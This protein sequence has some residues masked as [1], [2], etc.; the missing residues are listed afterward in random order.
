MFM[1]VMYLLCESIRYSDEL[2]KSSTAKIHSL[3][4]F[5]GLNCW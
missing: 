4:L 2:F 1:Y 3:Q 5:V